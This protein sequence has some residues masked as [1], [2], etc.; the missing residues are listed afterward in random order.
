MP[1]ANHKPDIPVPNSTQHPNITEPIIKDTF[2]D[3]REHAVDALL[4]NIDGYPWIVDFLMP[5][6]GDDSA[7]VQHDVNR[8]NVYQNYEHIKNV[9]LR[10][11]SPIS[12]IHNPNDDTLKISGEAHIIPT[13]VPNVGAMFIADGGYNNKVVYTITNVER[14]TLSRASV[15]KIEYSVA[16]YVKEHQA[17][18]EDLLSKVVR[19]RYFHRDRFMRGDDSIVLE[20]EHEAIMYLKYNIK[21][22]IEYY[23][24]SFFDKQTATLLIP[25]PNHRIY[26]PFIIEFVSR[27]VTTFDTVLVSRLKK[28]N[29]ESDAYLSQ[30]TILD[31]LYKRQE[32][33]LLHCNEKMGLVSVDQF[34]Y[35]PELNTIRYTGVSDVVYPVMPD[36][37]ITTK[38]DIKI[39]RFLEMVL[40]PSMPAKSKLNNIF[41]NT[42][43]IQG[44]VMSII[45]AIHQDGYYIFGEPFY[46]GDYV[47]SLLEALCLDFIRRKKLNPVHVKLLVEKFRA[48]GRIEQFYYLPI[49]LLMMRSLVG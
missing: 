44:R 2:V 3:T 7:I 31:V 16:F 11:D 18:Y 36:N 5:I 25:D 34:S 37:T 45:P 28:L 19:T 17:R 32:G 48:W 21:D 8:L 12:P 9:E 26:D 47:D 1:I 20:E 23:F 41:S 30:D 27:L 43:I 10:V 29:I 40:S 49:L 15:Y 4:L 39:K 6:V 24:E 33:L 35:R 38:E 14:K 42:T 13:I 46:N 22:I